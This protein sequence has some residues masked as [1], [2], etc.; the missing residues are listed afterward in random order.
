M[1]AQVNPNVKAGD[2]PVIRFD[3]VGELRFMAAAAGFVMCR[4]PGCYPTIRTMA[5]WCALSDRPWRAEP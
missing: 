5:E 1:R 2:I 3:D 4:R